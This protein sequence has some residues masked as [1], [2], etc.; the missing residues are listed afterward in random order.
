MQKTDDM[1][2]GTWNKEV[3]NRD[4]TLQTMEMSKVN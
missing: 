2:M 1:Q 4:R 3:K